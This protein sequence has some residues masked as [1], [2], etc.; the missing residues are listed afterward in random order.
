MEGDG[1]GEGGDVTSSSGDRWGRRGVAARGGEIYWQRWE[2]R[3]GRCGRVRATAVARDSPLS[4]ARTPARSRTP[5]PPPPRPPLP[6]APADCRPPPAT[7]SRCPSPP[8]HLPSSPP[9]PLCR[10]P[11]PVA[12]GM[13]VPAGFLSLF[14]PAISRRGLQIRRFRVKGSAYPRRR[15]D[16]ARTEVSPFYSYASISTPR[17]PDAY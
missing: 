8:L 16:G 3:A 2:L 7:L 11:P 1:D 5:P 10:P 9:P 6:L 14:R 15:S 4:H 12:T 13:G 17:R